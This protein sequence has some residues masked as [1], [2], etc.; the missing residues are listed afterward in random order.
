MRL[1][2][3][4]FESLYTA[5]ISLGLAGVLLTH[6]AGGFPVRHVVVNLIA[7]AGLAL[8]L[9]A[10]I[11]GPRWQA[12][13][14]YGSIVLLVLCVFFYASRHRSL[15]AG[16]AVFTFGC[17][18]T[19]VALSWALPMFRFAPLTGPYKTATS[20]FN[21]IDSS[22]EDKTP[23]GHRELMVQLWYPAEPSRKP[24]AS[25]RRPPETTRISSYQCVLKTSSRLDAPLAKTGRPFPILLFNPAWN[26]RRTQNT[27][28]VEELASHGFVVAAIDHTHNSEPVAFPGW[29][30]R[31]GGSCTRDGG[32]VE[33]YGGRG[34]AYRRHGSGPPG[35]RQ[36]LRAR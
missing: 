35:A 34:A 9:H 16:V 17:I 11:E 21:M 13:P 36:P 15:G 18:A 22:R 10:T 1:L 27:F 30:H 3:R 12:I 31:M 19:S 32:C 28:L 24:L 20:V 5:V 7:L 6:R 33:Q 4:P 26:G 2:M 23:N 8:L 14:A 25:Y 29:T